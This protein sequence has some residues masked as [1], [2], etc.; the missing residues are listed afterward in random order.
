[1]LY[2][3]QTFWFVLLLALCVGFLVG[4]M[5]VGNKK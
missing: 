5:A 1:M 2:L 3:V 4:W